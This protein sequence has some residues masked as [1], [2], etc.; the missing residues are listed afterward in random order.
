MEGQNVTNRADNVRE[1]FEG[2]IYELWKGKIEPCNL[3]LQTIDYFK[4][5]LIITEIFASTIFLIE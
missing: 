2:E 5:S 1:D 4:W 3:L